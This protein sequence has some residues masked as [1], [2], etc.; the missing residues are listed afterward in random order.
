MLTTDK[1][2]TSRTPLG[3]HLLR[4]RL[5]HRERRLH[6]V[7]REL[8]AR[9]DARRALDGRVPAALG[10]AIADFEND[11]RAT[12]RRIRSAGPGDEP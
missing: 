9:A 10:R 1:S 2:T 8:R 4:E 7:V 5:E 3:T 6:L 11:L 12:R